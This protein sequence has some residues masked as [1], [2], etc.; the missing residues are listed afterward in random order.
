MV[1]VDATGQRY[2]PEHSTAP[3]RSKKPDVEILVGLLTWES[4]RKTQK[5]ESLAAQSSGLNEERRLHIV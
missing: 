1:T 3:L 5:G 2:Y 4:Q